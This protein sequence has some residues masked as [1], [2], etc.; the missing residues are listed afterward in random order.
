MSVFAEDNLPPLPTNEIFPSYLTPGSHDIVYLRLCADLRQKLHCVYAVDHLRNSALRIV[1][2]AED[3][4][5]LVAR[6]HAEWLK[7]L[8]RPLLAEITFLDCPRFGVRVSR[9]VGTGLNARLAADALGL[10]DPDN[11]VG[12]LLRCP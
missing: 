7:S 12:I 10:I 3:P 6:L 9:V 11:A 1:Q 4:R 2:V 5:P 8:P